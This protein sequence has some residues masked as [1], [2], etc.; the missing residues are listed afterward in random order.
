MKHLLLFLAG[1]FYLLSPALAQMPGWQWAK[2]TGLNR[3]FTIFSPEPKSIASDRAGNIYM[4]ATIGDTVFDMDG[5]PLATYGK[6]DILLSS[7]SCMGQ[8]RWSK[9][10]G[11]RNDSDRVM[12]VK[13]DSMGNVYLCGA[14]TL[15]HPAGSGNTG[16]IDTDTNIIGNSYRTMFIAKWDSS[17]HLL[18]WRQPEPDTIGYLGAN[19]YNSLIG[20]DLS[21]DGTV[22][23]AAY[24]SP[25]AYAGYRMTVNTPGVY[26]IRYDAQGNYLGNTA[27]EAYERSQAINYWTP[28][29]GT[30]FLYD[31]P[32]MRY[33]LYGHIGLYL[34]RQLGNITFWGPKGFVASFQEK[35]GKA[36]FVRLPSAASSSADTGNF[37]YNLTLDK[38]GNIYVLGAANASSIFCG[39]NFSNP[40]GQWATY[41]FKLDGQTGD[42]LWT[43]VGYRSQKLPYFNNNEYQ[44]NQ[45]GLSV[46]NGLVTIG[47]IF[48]D[49]LNFPGYSLNSNRSI[50]SNTLFLLQ[51]NATTGAI[52]RG[53]LI[54]S[55]M[56]FMS[57]VGHDPRGNFYFAGIVLD[58]IQFLNPNSTGSITFRSGNPYPYKGI[59]HFLAKWGVASCTCTPPVAAYTPASSSGNTLSYSY[60]GTTLG[61]DSLV[62]DWGDGHSTT[63]LSGFATP[64]MHTYPTSGKQY[65]VCV[66]VYGN[67]GSDQYCGLSAP[68]VVQHLSPSEK[69]K[70]YPNPAKDMLHVDDPSAESYQIIS[71]SGQV[72][73]QSTVPPNKDLVLSALPPG[74][75]ILLL[76]RAAGGKERILFSKL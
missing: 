45:S 7:F 42:T 19:R 2:R 56:A 16:H 24:L 61:I 13:T 65:N 52:N 21:P 11:N 27:L 15:K 72:L 23:F 14:M 17:G 59:F 26:V 76:H 38:S 63:V 60:T 10:I 50:D 12:N 73:Q 62:W 57:Q 69:I 43:K 29:W 32:H 3:N 30:Q 6:N 68:V 49:S 75:Y 51:L 74:S 67:C 34:S 22:H 5:H 4:A 47:G 54:K 25:G 1:L 70:V 9:V 58:S 33:L 41:I 71:L 55:R 35:T 46:S 37:A 64:I 8:Y 18:W 66:N 36:V 31:A 39:R 20:M 53:Q 48:I 44:I 28:Q 40:L